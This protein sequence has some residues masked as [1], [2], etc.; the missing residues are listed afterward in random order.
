MANVLYLC[1]WLPPDFG[2]V[3]Q[4]SVAFARRRA[5]L[6]DDVL[7]AGFSSTATSV[8][9]V[10]D[11]APGRL[12]IVR[13]RTRPIDRGRFGR[14]M[15]WTA[16][17]NSRL[18]WSVRRRLALCD[19]VVF[20][21][22]PPLLL[23]WLGPLNLALRKRLVYRITDFHPECLMAEFDRPP[24]LLRMF[25]RLTL[26]W[27]R[28]V[29]R[30][31]ALGEDARRRLLEMGIPADRVTLQRDE[32]PITIDPQATPLERPAEL[33]GKAILLYSGNFGLAHDHETLIAGYERHHRQGSGRVAL[34]INAIGA[35]ADL[36]ET[37]LRA[38]GL[39]VHRSRPA[40]LEQLNSLLVTP[41]AHLI[42]LRD[43]F[44]GYVLPSK[45]YA[46]VASGREVLF[47]GDAASDVDLICRQAP[48]LAYQRVA[49]GDAAGV[50]AALETIASRSADAVGESNALATIPGEA[51]R[52]EA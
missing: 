11:L 19:E 3:G 50:A 12:E 43:A 27:R 25:Y 41:D 1:D 14:R 51:A 16:W 40:P 31:E 30:F 29:D 17:A 28:R 7:L 26:F 48:S 13:L 46:C 22:S 24:W 18:L 8:E 9:A 5:G 42:T 34:W 36:V 15:L 39:P 4:Y 6:G 10:D 52:G 35:K 23:H 33:A 20:T 44:V 38:L 32:A 47:I 21:G 37:R 49:T 45:V 2:A